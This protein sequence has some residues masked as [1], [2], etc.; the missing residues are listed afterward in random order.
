MD[1]LANS[2]WIIFRG[3][4]S[5]LNLKIQD[6]NVKEIEKVEEVLK[7]CEDMKY[8]LF[9]FIFIFVVVIYSKC[10]KR[11]QTIILS[12]RYGIHFINDNDNENNRLDIYNNN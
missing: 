12:N 11:L 9:D 2:V 5:Y 1:S 3:I 6:I 10:K 7:T 8:I 4:N